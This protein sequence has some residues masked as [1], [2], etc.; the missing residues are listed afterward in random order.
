[1]PATFP[2]N[3]AGTLRHEQPPEPRRIAEHHWPEGTVPLV[4]ICCITYNHEKFIAQCIEGFLIQETTFPLEILI[5]DDASTDGTADI[6]QD[7]QKRHPKLIRAILQRENQFSQ[8]RRPGAIVRSLAKG[9][10]IALCEGDDYWTCPGKIQKQHQ[11][12]QDYP[13]A[14]MAAHDVVTVDEK[15]RLI[16]TEKTK[17]T[18]L[19][20]AKIKFISGEEIIGGHYLA[21]LSLFFRNINNYEARRRDRNIV[22]GDRYLFAML[23]TFGG[24]IMSSQ[25][26][27]AY[28]IHPGGVCSG[29]DNLTRMRNMVV[30]RLAIVQDIPPAYCLPACEDLAQTSWNNFVSAVRTKNLKH[31]VFFLKLYLSGFFYCIRNIS[32]SFKRVMMTVKMQMRI[33]CIPVRTFLSGGVKRK[34]KKLVSRKKVV[35]C[36]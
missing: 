34:L 25:K 29:S 23:S 6:I 11:W 16:G 7:Y 5:H 20:E 28:R 4:S 36:F 15:G 12:L 8:G 3:Q 2:N 26:M 9:D 30:S 14:M 17:P 19:T 22:H 13:K 35:S 24:V 27:G 33:A 21:T 1:M 10:F 18:D 31:S 32:P